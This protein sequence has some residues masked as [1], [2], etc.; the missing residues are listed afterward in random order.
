MQGEASCPPPQNTP[1]PSL[2]VLQEI[3]DLSQQGTKPCQGKMESQKPLGKV[4]RLQA[5]E[6]KRGEEKLPRSA[7]LPTHGEEIINPTQPRR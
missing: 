5:R 2:P 3:P 1:G 4:P 7:P 6:D